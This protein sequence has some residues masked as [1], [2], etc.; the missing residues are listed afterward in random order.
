ME[1]PA[2]TWNINRLFLYVKVFFMK[3]KLTVKH[4]FYCFIEKLRC[5]EISDKRLKLHFLIDD[6]LMRIIENLA[7]IIL[8]PDNEA[9]CKWAKDICLCISEFSRGWI[10]NWNLRPATYYDYLWRESVYMD[11]PGRFDDDV[12]WRFKEEGINITQDM[13]EDAR[14]E[15]QSFMEWLAIELSKGFVTNR[16]IFER[17]NVK[18]AE[19]YHFDG[20]FVVIEQKPR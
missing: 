17:L 9:R 13:I 6:K 14:R 12:K 5:L 10:K 7:L 16:Q 1:E 20:G 4:D 2:N 3:K 15:V 11:S 8:C 18:L 19:G